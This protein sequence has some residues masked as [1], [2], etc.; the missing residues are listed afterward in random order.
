MNKNIFDLSQ[1]YTKYRN[2]TKCAQLVLSDLPLM[3]ADIFYEII[4][5][6]D[7]K[8]TI[9]GT[10][11]TLIIADKFE[12]LKPVPETRDMKLIINTT[13]YA[14]NI[15]C[16]L[17][18]MHENFLNSFSTICTIIDDNICVA[19]NSHVSLCTYSNQNNFYNVVTDIC[20]HWYSSSY[21]RRIHSK[22]IFI[23]VYDN[24]Y[25]EFFNE[26]KNVSN[27]STEIILINTDNNYFNNSNHFAC[28]KDLLKIMQANYTEL[29]LVV[30][31]DTVFIWIKDDNI[32][33]RIFNNSNYSYILIEKLI[34]R[35]VS[36]KCVVNLANKIIYGGKLL[37]NA[38]KC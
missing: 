14:H 28:C 36:E 17:F 7:L 6:E 38:N 10:F 2:S 35:M 1:K 32:N 30:T 16:E 4:F 33:S 29:K 27:Y 21:I 26:I 5:S 19:N 3:H 13:M 24:Q 34:R 11:L 23:H 25:N 20:V 9:D 31:Y 12:F 37:K 8:M 15:S 22:I 18:S